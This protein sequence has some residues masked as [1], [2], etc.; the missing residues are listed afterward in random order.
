MIDLQPAPVP[1]LSEEWIV[2]HRAVLVDVLGAERHRPLKW[3]AMAGATGVAAAISTLLLV[4]GTSQNPFVGWTA[5]PTPPATGQLTSADADC[6]SALAQLPPTPDGAAGPASLVPELSDVR[7]PYTVTVFG[8]D[9][10][11]EVVCVAA[12]DGNSTLRRITGPD[13][14]VAPGAIRVDQISVL[15]DSRLVY[16]VVEGRTGEGVTGVTLDLADGSQVTAT[17][18]N[19]VFLAWW[20]GSQTVSSATVS[21]AGG[22]TSSPIP[23]GT[24]SVSGGNAV[25]HFQNCG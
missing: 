23:L 15:P 24:P 22:T 12:P 25:C 1:E 21:T 3:V 19:G 6:Q 10:G 13:A 14:P 8:N 17:T 5:A 18:G 7:G 4:S 20:P 2:A 11:T 16:T 9:T